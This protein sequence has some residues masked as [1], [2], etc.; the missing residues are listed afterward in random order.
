M[1]CHVMH[2]NPGF[3][4]WGSHARLRM[5]WDGQIRK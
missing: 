5:E 1:A 3:G 4:V 2:G